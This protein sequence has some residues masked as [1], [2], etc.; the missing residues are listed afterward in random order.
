MTS[1]QEKLIEIKFYDHLG[2]MDRKIARKLLKSELAFRFSGITVDD[3]FE[4]ILT[5]PRTAWK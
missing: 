5:L 2:F 1:T 3:V 4:H